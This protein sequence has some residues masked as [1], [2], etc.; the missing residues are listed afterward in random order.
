[1][2]RITRIFLA[3]AVLFLVACTVEKP[4]NEEIVK[5]VEPEKKET[6]KYWESTVASNPDSTLVGFT[7]SGFN[8]SQCIYTDDNDNQYVGY[9]NGD[10]EMIIAQRKL[11]SGPW[12]Y[13]NVGQKVEWDS[14]NYITMAKDKAGRLH[15]SGN[16]HVDPLVFF[17]TDE[18]GDISTLH[19][20]KSLVGTDENRV[21]YPKFISLED[22]RL[23]F[24]YRTGKS[25]DGD[26]IY[27][28]LG[29]N[30]LWSRFLDTPLTDGEGQ[31]NAYFIDAVKGPEG[32][33]HVTW[34]WRETSMAE[35]NHDLCYAY[36]P[37]FKNWYA[38]DGTKMTL[39]MKLS[40]KKLLVD[41]IPQNGGCLNGGQQIGF[42]AN[43]NPIIIYFKFDEAGYSQIYLARFRNGLWK[44]SKLTS[45]TWRWEIKGG[46]SLT[47]RISISAPKLE[48]DGTLTVVYH[49]VYEDAPQFNSE[50][51]IDPYSLQAIKESSPRS[52]EPRYGSW[53]KKIYTP[54]SG[55]GTLSVK[56]SYDI[57]GKP[58]M[59]RWESL[60]SFGDVK[61]DVEIPPASELRVVKLFY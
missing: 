38:V 47:K 12:R 57:T 37:D 53:V 51:W 10:H 31:R 19:Q 16:M 3:A 42:D 59:L 52:A 41:P 61:P 5:P 56:T 55:A 48:P 11:P 9:Y 23:L 35:T 49:F 22:G 43:G 14:H 30:G 39:P 24:H 32:N 21:T 60:G 54:Y 50:I 7:Q 46:G 28:V 6:F 18:T 8:V 17:S 44:I 2:N 1:M 20:V 27:D 58:Y 25:G 40:D 4:E 13:C 45:S 34:V 26:E 29:D 36:T 33:Y 15:V